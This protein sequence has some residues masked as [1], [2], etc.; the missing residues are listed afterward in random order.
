MP[1]SVTAKRQRNT[2]LF[3]YCV[4]VCLAGLSSPSGV[5][6][7]AHRGKVFSLTWLG[8]L[9]GLGSVLLSCGPGGET[10]RWP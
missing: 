3:C 7:G 8:P 4:C 1:D 5:Q 9:Q 10:V 6:V 2:L